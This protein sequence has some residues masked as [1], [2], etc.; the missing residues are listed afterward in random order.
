MQWTDKLMARLKEEKRV[1]LKKERE[2]NYKIIL[3]ALTMG[4]KDITQGTT[5]RNLNKTE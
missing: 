4:N 3:N 2:R 5:I 1:S